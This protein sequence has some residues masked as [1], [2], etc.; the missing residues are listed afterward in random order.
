[1]SQLPWGQVKN[2]HQLSETFRPFRV[3]FCNGVKWLNQTSTYLCA[4]ENI[5]NA[6]LAFGCNSLTPI[7][8]KISPSSETTWTFSFSKSGDKSRCLSN[9]LRSRKQYQTFVG[10][11]QLVE[12]LEIS[13]C[14]VKK[15]WNIKFGIL[16]NCTWCVP[17][18]LKCSKSWVSRC[19]MFIY[20]FFY[21]IP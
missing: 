17:L 2:V 20:L 21:K 6:S 10:L 7:E 19:F 8:L 3:H 4:V 14:M 15:T 1:M 11:C 12:T 5:P 18:W 9:E 13:F 16:R